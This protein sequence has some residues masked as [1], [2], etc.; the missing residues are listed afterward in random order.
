M[1]LFNLSSSFSP[2][3][4]HRRYLPTPPCLVYLLPII[5]LQVLSHPVFQKL[6]PMVTTLYPVVYIG[7]SIPIQPV[8]YLSKRT[9]THPLSNVQPLPRYPL[10]RTA[11]GRAA[12]T[13]YRGDRGHQESGRAPK[14]TLPY[15]HLP[16]SQSRTYLPAPTPARTLAM[17]RHRTCSEKS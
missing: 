15:P 9:P 12:E 1:H 10:L 11:N 13:R 5:V 7:F 8:Y 3:L 2:S 6:P 14:H 16:R 4:S 17:K